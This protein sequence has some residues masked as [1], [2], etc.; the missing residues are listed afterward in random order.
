MSDGKKKKNKIMYEIVL[1]DLKLVE[2][3][4]LENSTIYINRYERL[5]KIR[6]MPELVDRMV[7]IT[8][9]F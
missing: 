9:M 1:E 6:K 5:I 7:V 2:D 8:E 3:R 4:I